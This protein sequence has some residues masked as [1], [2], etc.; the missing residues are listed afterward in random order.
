MFPSPLWPVLGPHQSISFENEK[1]FEEQLLPARMV[2][3]S[4][5][6]HKADS[7]SY[8]LLLNEK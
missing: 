6:G 7:Q 1:G 2:Y 3:F 5:L 8:T 4:H